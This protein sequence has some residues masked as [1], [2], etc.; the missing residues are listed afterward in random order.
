MKIQALLEEFHLLHENFSIT[1]MTV[2]QLGVVHRFLQSLVYE[3]LPEQINPQ[4]KNVAGYIDQLRNPAVRTAVAALAKG[5]EEAMAK[6]SPTKGDRSQ[7]QSVDADGRSFQARA[8]GFGPK[9]ERNL[10]VSQRELKMISY[11]ADALEDID[12]YNV[13]NA[14]ITNKD[15]H[16][17][18]SAFLGNAANTPVSALASKGT[19]HKYATDLLNK[20]QS[21]IQSASETPSAVKKAR[22]LDLN[23]YVFLI[24]M[25]KRQARQKEA[26][27]SYLNPIAVR[28]FQNTVNRDLDYEAASDSLISAGFIKRTESGYM[29][30]WDAIK[31][32]Q[33]ELLSSVTSA[34]NF[35]KEHGMRITPGTPGGV[36]GLNK[37]EKAF[38]N[39]M[40]SLERLVPDE[41]VKL[42]ERTIIS[43]M[44]DL[45]SE[46]SS[47]VKTVVNNFLSR[48]D[49]LQDLPERNRIH[50]FIK[51][52]ITLS[53][54]KL[55]ARMIM[56]MVKGSSSDM[57]VRATVSRDM[58]PMLQN[59]GKQM[60]A[61][62]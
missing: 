20:R 40:D 54:I 33:E 45:T 36:R 55:V 8:Y 52:N 27:A 4:A 14:T 58:R 61:P 5:G 9:D 10:P 28:L 17:L 22:E 50:H 16:S 13:E 51:N 26:W 3:H 19:F 37:E 21:E 41:F 2:K 48:A 47:D 23:A 57:N 62:R 30:D 34:V 12:A 39:M 42:A 56:S 59:I 46:G 44:K 43:I 35:A 38:R 7:M 49:T 29:P 53:T 15:L 32:F 60:R 18:V 1:Q 24:S 6:F 11:V 25:Q 31:D